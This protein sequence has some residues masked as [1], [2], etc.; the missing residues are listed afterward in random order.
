ML[1]K[2]H[3]NCAV[4]AGIISSY[5][6]QIMVKLVKVNFKLN[7]FKSTKLLFSVL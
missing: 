6:T 4:T 5:V 2:A 1:E 3:M 7:T